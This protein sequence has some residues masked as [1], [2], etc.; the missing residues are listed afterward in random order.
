MPIEM[1]LVLEY[2]PLEKYERP[3]NYVNRVLDET[4]SI[5]RWEGWE[6]FQWICWIDTTTF[7]S[8]FDV[9]FFFSFVFRK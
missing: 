4:E 8:A 6:K 2:N 5:R 3:I 1:G 9:K 7:P